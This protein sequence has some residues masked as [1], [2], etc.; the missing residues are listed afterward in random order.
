MNGN[1][2]E[3]EEILYLDVD[4]FFKGKNINVDMNSDK[5]KDDKNEK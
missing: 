3:E 1:K 2:K 4:E 5:E